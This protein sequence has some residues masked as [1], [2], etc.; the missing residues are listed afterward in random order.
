[1]GA[2]YQGNPG[3]KSG[4]GCRR[5]RAAY[6]ED[7]L[8]IGV[9]LGVESEYPGQLRRHVKMIDTR[10]E[11]E[12]TQIHTGQVDI[13]RLACECRVCSGDVALRLSRLRIHNVHRSSGDAPRRKAGNRAPRADAQI[14]ND[15]GGAGVGDRRAPQDREALRRTQQRLGQRRGWAAKK[16]C[17]SDARQV[18]A[19]HLGIL[20][21]ILQTSVEEKHPVGR[22]MLRPA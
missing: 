4:I 14:T 6:L 12:P 5:E 22:E 19:H 15:D 7:K 21:R 3:V 2:I 1:L 13:E 8:R 9:A 16:H 18:P 10:S 17:Q 11:R 20:P